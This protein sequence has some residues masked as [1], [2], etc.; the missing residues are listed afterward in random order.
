MPID[1]ALQL[2]YDLERAMDTA[3]AAID[4]QAIW[5]I[6]AERERDTAVALLHQWQQF[7]RH[8]RTQLGAR[9]AGFLATFDGESP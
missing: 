2:V 1:T 8:K 7:H 9:T 3:A 6:K 5:T 4:Q